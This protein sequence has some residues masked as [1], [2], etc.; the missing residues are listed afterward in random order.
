MATE[1]ETLGLRP[2][3]ARAPDA[4]PRV[5]AI[6]LTFNRLHR[7]QACLPAV[8]SQTRPPD[9]ILV[10]DNASTDGTADYLMS[11]KAS[12]PGLVVLRTPENLGPAGGFAAGLTWAL[13]GGYDYAWLFD[14][15]SI[16]APDCLEVQLREALRDGKVFVL[17]RNVDEDGNS[18]YYA[19]WRGVLVP[20]EAVRVAGVPDRDLFYSKEDT[21]WYRRLSTVAGLERLRAPEAVVRYWRFHPTKRA[22]WKYYY[23]GRNTVH[24]RLRVQVTR[25][26]A[27]RLSRMA[28]VLARLWARA[29]FLE[30]QKLR[31]CGFLALG[32]WHG[33]LGRTGKIVDPAR[34]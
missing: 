16:P 17:S 28:V 12:S 15:D 7:L 25:S 22:A 13:E 8:Q 24:Y 5:C 30:D 29:I 1:R 4:V 26:W 23:F 32:I 9:T 27:W 34:G 19:A 3:D 6:I 14:D 11:M 2:E 31:K 20:A 33:L 18:T 10:V 21:E